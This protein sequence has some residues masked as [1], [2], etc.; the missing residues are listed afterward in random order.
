MGVE[1]SDGEFV[2]AQAL[3]DV[4]LEVEFRCIG[5]QLQDRDVIRH[6]WIFCV[7]PPR[8]IHDQQGMRVGGHGSGDL[9]EVQFHR[10]GID[11]WQ[12]QPCGCSA[13]QTGR[14]ED[15]DPFVARIPRFARMRVSVPC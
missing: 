3:P 4:F 15:I 5:R 12:D 8:S 11:A 1:Y 14:P 2:G 7:M 10:F 6:P 9:Y 13:S